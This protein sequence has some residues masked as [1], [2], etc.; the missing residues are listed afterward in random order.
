MCAAPTIVL[1][2]EILEWTSVPRLCADWLWTVARQQGTTCNSWL[3]DRIVVLLFSLLL[4]NVQIP[5]T[6]LTKIVCHGAAVQLASC[7]VHVVHSKQGEQKTGV[8]R[9]R[10]WL[11]FAWKLGRTE[12]SGQVLDGLTRWIK[13]WSLEG[14]TFIALHV[15]NEAVAMRIQCKFLKLQRRIF[16]RPR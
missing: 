1:Q 5:L 4:E 16:W 6:V 10:V 11:R 13:T 12:K 9:K 14:Y 2:S 3:H 15:V 7:N 8:R